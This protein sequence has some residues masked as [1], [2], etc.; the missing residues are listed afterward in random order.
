M[1]LDLRDLLTFGGLGL[2]YLGISQVNDGIALASIGI[3]LF[4][5]GLR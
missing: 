5:I 2:I 4:V 3:G 1:K